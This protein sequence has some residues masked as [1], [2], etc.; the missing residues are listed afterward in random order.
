VVFSR[1]YVSSL[2]TSVYT[3][4][5]N[6]ISISSNDRDYW[7]IPT[8]ATTVNG[9]TISGVVSLIYRSVCSDR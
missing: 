4:D 3:G 1:A 8:Q 9:N 6:Y 2:D 7:R 5:I